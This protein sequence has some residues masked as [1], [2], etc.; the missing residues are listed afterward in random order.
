MTTCPVDSSTSPCP[1]VDVGI[2]ATPIIQMILAG[3][4]IWFILRLIGGK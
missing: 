2:Q 3:L 4:V 1:T